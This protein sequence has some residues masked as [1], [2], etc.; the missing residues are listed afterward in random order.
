[1]NDLIIKL[2]TEVIDLMR[3]E[4]NLIYDGDN[5]TA[6]MYRITALE[7][8]RNYLKKY[9]YEIKNTDEIKNIKGFGEGTLKRIDEILKTGKLTEI[10]Y[11]KKRIKKHYKLHLLT[12][13]LCK[14]IGIGSI[15]AL[16]LIE[17]YNIKSLND[18]KQRVLKGEIVVNDKIK[19]GLKYEGKYE[20]VIKRK[21][22]TK[23][24][25][26]IK[27]IISSSV[28]SMICG[29]YRRGSE[30]SHDIDLLIWNKKYVTEEDVN[31]SDKLYKIVE[32]L[33]KN[34]I[35][36]DDIT[37]LNYKNKYMGFAKYKN[38]I[39][40]IDIRFIPYESLYT[41]ISYFTGS[42]NHNIKMRN[43]A[44]KLAYKLNEY[45][46]FNVMGK[47]VNINSE[48]ELFSILKMKYLEPYER[49]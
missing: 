31:K 21:Y 25:S 20:T 46:L 37:N 18:L 17:D 8:N 30:Q 28:E 44:K 29:S 16:K 43:R 49:D 26:K 15:T 45:G 19:L 48:E 23:I 4:I 32:K 1:M 9:P 38:K 7:R 34:D 36:T 12:E 14:V 33:K 24:Y 2:L 22:V 40:R 47:R 41:A 27:K 42:F 35:I 3:I 13:E 39:Y 11:L 10:T 5:K 6:N